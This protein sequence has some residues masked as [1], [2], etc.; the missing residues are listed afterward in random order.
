M[1]RNS[2][3]KARNRNRE[4]LIESRER[5]RQ[6][7]QAGGAGTSRRRVVENYDDIARLW[8]VPAER[9]PSNDLTYEDMLAIGEM[10]GEVKK[11]GFTLAEVE[12][13]PFHRAKPEEVGE[14][15]I[16]L[17]SIDVGNF[18]IELS[19]AHKFHSQCIR[20]WLMNRASC[21][22][23]RISIPHPEFIIDD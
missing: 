10:I 15:A 16:C 14:C 20:T 7:R 2:V 6:R 23:C 3:T 21:P 8:D 5:R 13:I 12:A 1:G 22:V 11:P 9:H 17:S 18:V 19:C 4:A